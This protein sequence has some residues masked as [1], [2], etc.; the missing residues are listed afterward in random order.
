MKSF[1]SVL[2][3][4]ILVILVSAASVVAQTAKTECLVRGAQ[5]VS[6]SYDP[7]T[8]IGHVTLSHPQA[9]EVIDFKHK[10]MHRC[11]LF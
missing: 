2:V 7:V 1:I 5:I 9:G 6:E 4:T 10:R 11:I 8:R 3:A